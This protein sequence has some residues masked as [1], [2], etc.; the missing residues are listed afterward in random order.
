MGPQPNGHH[1]HVPSTEEESSNEP[2]VAAPAEPQDDSEAQKEQTPTEEEPSAKKAEPE[3]TEK[4]SE[5]LRLS[6]SSQ[7]QADG[8][9]QS[10]KA[11]FQPSIELSKSSDAEVQPKHTEG[12]LVSQTDC[13]NG[14]ESMDSLDSHSLQG[15]SEGEKRTAHS[16]AQCSNEPELE[17]HKD[18]HESNPTQEH[19]PQDGRAE[20][21][22]VVEH[23]HTEGGSTA[24]MSEQLK[25][26]T[27]RTE[28]EP[29]PPPPHPPLVVD[30]QRLADESHHLSRNLLAGAQIGMPPDFYGGPHELTQSR[31]PCKT[32]SPFTPHCHS[33]PDQADGGWGK[34]TAAISRSHAMFALLDTVVKK[35]EGYSV[36]QLERLYSLLS[37]SIYRHRREYEKTTLLEHTN[38]QQVI[39]LLLTRECRN[40]RSQTCCWRRVKWSVSIH[41]SPLL[42]PPALLWVRLVSVF[43]RADLSA[44]GADYT[45]PP[46]KARGTLSA[47]QQFKTLYELKTFNLRPCDSGAVHAAGRLS[48]TSHI[49]APVE[50][51]PPPHSFC[52]RLTGD[53]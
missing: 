41:L 21:G 14:N 4:H 42:C 38:T 28:E 43:Q 1:P 7:P 33:H 11:D 32:L 30:H 19:P 15:S 3:N 17:E 48:G 53:Q 52:L 29:H 20:T 25:G 31:R 45:L 34:Y 51:P 22:N 26:I 46:V 2:P 47:L 49:A 44:D 50:T 37:Q 16:T 40:M 36:E 18:K 27:E 10:K 9:G 23:Q 35:S 24:E 8:D 5:L 39:S 13:V 6:G 12:V